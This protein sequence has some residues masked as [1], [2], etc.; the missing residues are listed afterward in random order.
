ME[1]NLGTKVFG[2]FNADGGL[3]ICGYEWGYSKQDELNDTENA[4]KGIVIDHLPDVHFAA[5]RDRGYRYDNRIIKWFEIFQ[6]P[7]NPKE[8]T[9]FDK[10]IVQTNW[11]DGMA[12][13]MGGDYWK[14][15]NDDK[16]I[17]NFIFHIEKLRPRVIFFMGSKLI[18]MLNGDKVLHRF[19][20]IVGRK[21]DEPSYIKKDNTQSFKLCFQSFE[22]CEIICF[23]HPSSTIGL[24]DNFDEQ[25]IKK[26]SKIIADY[27]NFKNCL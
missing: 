5:K 4:K 2:G 27:K 21:I 20:N 6:H 22:N 26:I 12:N 19:E 16:Q 11:G 13:N 14:L 10:C 15:Y 18:E 9:C 1:L 17:D 3:M 25:V 8:E 24:L 23:P 7:L